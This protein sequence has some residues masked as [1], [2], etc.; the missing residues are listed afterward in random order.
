MAW[1]QG[2]AY[3]SNAAREILLL[4]PPMGAEGAAVATVGA[5]SVDAAATAQTTIED[6]GQASTHP[7]CRPLVELIDMG[8]MGALYDSCITVST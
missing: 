6:Y 2:K 7:T 5:D 1:L 4:I 3:T 8:L